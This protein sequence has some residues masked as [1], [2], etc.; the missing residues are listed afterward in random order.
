MRLMT[1]VSF[2]LIKHFR[3]QKL[4]VSIKYKLTTGEWQ[5]SLEAHNSEPFILR[6]VQTPMHEMSDD[7]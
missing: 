6:K 7:N 1:I 5:A 2:D 3:S 4:L